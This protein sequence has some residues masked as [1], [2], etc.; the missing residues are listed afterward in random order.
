MKILQWLRIT[1][2]IATLLVLPGA[3]FAQIAI[4]ITVA[5]PPLPVY[6][7]PICPEVNYIWTPGYWAWGDDGY[8]WVP[9][10][11]VPAP[12]PGLLWTP[13]YWGWRDGSYIWN[14]GYWGPEV[15]FYGGVD[16]G[17]GY[18]G[19][20]FYGGRWSGDTFS[21]NTAVMNVNTAVIHNT[22]VD[23]KIIVNN[24]SRV[25][26]NGGRGGIEARPTPAQMAAAH[27][28][29][30]GPVA[31]QTRQVGLAREDRQN[32]VSV[33]HGLPPHA[34]LQRPATSVADFERAAPARG[35]RPANTRAEVVRPE[36]HTAA[37]TRNEAR[38]EARTETHPATRT[39]T[40]TATRPETRT[41]SHPTARTET[42]PATPA[43]T[44]SHSAPRTETHT[45]RR[46]ETRTESRSESHTATPARTESRPVHE[47]RTESHPAPAPRAE[48]HPAPAPRAESHPVPA[49]R[50]ES[51]PATTPREES[52]PH[53]A[54]RPESHPAPA[55]RP[56][57]HPESHPAAK[58]NE[59]HPQ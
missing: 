37:P 20:G 7:Q 51:H 10:T 17:F 46:P 1:F 13:G 27:H 24:D 44:E 25:S 32:Y 16:Y 12:E 23:R 9:G 34:A 35:A 29:R 42:R 39:E 11:W 3:T 21:Y 28:K 49:P 53:Q 55:V 56:A 43:R 4:S 30:F 18:G 33:N 40:H 41:E 15:G 26:Y 57:S 48:S 6:E 58:S 36:S 8:Y 47:P 52:H 14:A 2:L 5:P 31:A 54:A 19:E 22:Y 50:A 38:P 59:K 45:A